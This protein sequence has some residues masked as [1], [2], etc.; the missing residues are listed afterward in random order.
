MPNSTVKDHPERLV[1]P[2]K[3]V[4]QLKITHYYMGSVNPH[5]LLVTSLCNQFTINNNSRLLPN[6]LCLLSPHSTPEQSRPCRVSSKTI[7]VED[8]PFPLDVE[9]IHTW[10]NVGIVSEI[11]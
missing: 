6:T 2:D 1:H 10:R 4:R 8:K 9:Y 5:Y 3:N 7:F 11:R